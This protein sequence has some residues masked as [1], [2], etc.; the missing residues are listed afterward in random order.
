M[1]M[2]WNSDDVKTTAHA[3]VESVKNLK[4]TVVLADKVA[5]LSA[6]VQEQPKW[7]LGTKIKLF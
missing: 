1:P 5:Q 2:L 4:Y 3:Q 7:Q 6:R